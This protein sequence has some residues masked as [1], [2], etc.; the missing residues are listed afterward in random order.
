MAKTLHRYSRFEHFFPAESL[1][2]FVE[3]TVKIAPRAYNL[4]LR[5]V[6]PI[7]LICHSVNISSVFIHIFLQSWFFFMHILC[8]ILSLHNLLMGLAS[9]QHCFAVHVLKDSNKIYFPPW[10][11]V[12]ILEVKQS[13]SE[14]PLKRSIVQKV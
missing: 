1:R 2:F 7:T 5:S 12:L 14:I 6:A 13:V 9:W 8:T 11:K 10:S 4:K 3:Q